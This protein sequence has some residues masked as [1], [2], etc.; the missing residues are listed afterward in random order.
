MEKVK[1]FQIGLGSF[2][3]YGFEKFIELQKH[4]SDVE[5]ELCGVCDT[6]FEKLEKAE[7]FAESQELELNTFT[8]IEEIYVEAEKQASEDAKIL[9]YDAGPT[10]LH[11]EHIFRSLRNDFFHLAEKPPSMNREDHIK[12]KKLMLDNEVRFTVDFIERENPVVK[13]ALEITENE[14][15]ERIEAFRESS[16][17]IQKLLQPVERINVKGGAVIDKMSH[18]AYILDFVELG[19]LKEVEKEFFM[20]YKIGSDSFMSINSGKASRLDEDTASATCTAR[21]SGEADVVLHGSWIGCTE[22]TESKA[23]ELEE[24]TSHNPVESEFNRAG[25]KGFVDDE[26]RFFVLEGSRSLFG[27]LL[28]NR[29]FDLETGEEIETPSLMHD[30]LYRVIESSVR[31]AAGL[32]NNALTEEEIDDYMNLLFDISEFFP[33]RDGFDALEDSNSRI[34]ERVVDNVFEAE[35][36]KEQ[37]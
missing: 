11:A 20:P 37:V 3:R 15:I 22:Q 31:C 26:C 9:I 30:Q 6:D 36:L 23:E 2:G 25:E 16:I 5:V 24:L 33:D 18:E 19:E 29:L 12:E 34:R 13:K 4:Y 28:H 8:K 14:K 21:V 27:D 35:G 32:E 17:G 10:E 7:K 1:V